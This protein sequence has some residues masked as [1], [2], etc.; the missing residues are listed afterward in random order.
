L[1]PCGSP[2]GGAASWADLLP[3]W[4]EPT[5]H[6]HALDAEYVSCSFAGRRS[7]VATLTYNTAPSGL[8]RDE[9]RGRR[10]PP[11][12]PR[13][14]CET[15]LMGNNTSPFLTRAR[16]RRRCHHPLPMHRRTPRGR[17][18]PPTSHVRPYGTPIVTSAS[19]ITSAGVGRRTRDPQ[20]RRS[21]GLI[22]KL[23][24]AMDRSRDQP[25]ATIRHAGAV[26]SRYIAKARA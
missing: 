3:S 11:A 19:P 5:C 25:S 20:T 4:L 7:G 22:G 16:Q 14:K 1:S 13:C 15:M 26:F 18:R 9:C 21:T 12:A 17:G 8:C 6:V 23:L 10:L 2:Q 24:D